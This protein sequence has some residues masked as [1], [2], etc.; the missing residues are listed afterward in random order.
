MGMYGPGVEILRRTA[1]KLAL[2]DQP[3]EELP[4]VA[5]ETLA[6]G[7][8]S[9]ALRTLAGQSRHDSSVE[10]FHQAMDELGSSV[11]AVEEAWLRRM[12]WAAE[13]IVKEKQHPPQP[14]FLD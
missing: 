7:L 9:L 13:A 2:G 1:V 3:V 5:A 12:L 10:L 6:R 4:M 14:G 11:S 8:D